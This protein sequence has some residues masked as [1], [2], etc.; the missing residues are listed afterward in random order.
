[1]YHYYLHTL[2]FILTTD[3][4]FTELVSREFWMQVTWDFYWC[5]LVVNIDFADV[6]DGDYGLFTS[7]SCFWQGNLTFDLG[8]FDGDNSNCSVVARLIFSIGKTMATKSYTTRRYTKL[9]GGWQIICWIVDNSCFRTH[10]LAPW[11]N[12]RLLS[13]RLSPQLKFVLNRTSNIS[14][15]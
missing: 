12:P 9:H 3:G 15:V 11:S 7:I 6:D 10:C 4:S 1:M 8:W 13:P 5:L 14:S 2:R